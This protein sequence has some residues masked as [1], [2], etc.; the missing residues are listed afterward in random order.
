MKM[1]VTQL[2]SLFDIPDLNPNIWRTR[3]KDC[4][5]ASDN[6]YVKFLREPESCLKFGRQ[7]FFP[8]TDEDRKK[9]VKSGELWYMT[10]D[11]R[12]K[13]AAKKLPIDK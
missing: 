10:A 7:F 2:T 6:F 9:L 4:T 12:K 13:L 11:D 1:R 5:Y 3:A 8:I